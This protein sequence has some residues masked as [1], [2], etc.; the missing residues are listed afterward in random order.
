MWQKGELIWLEITKRR[1]AGLKYGYVYKTQERSDH[2]VKVAVYCV[3]QKKAELWN[4]TPYIIVKAEGNKLKMVHSFKKEIDA[5]IKGIEAQE[6]NKKQIATSF[7]QSDFYKAMT[8]YN[9]ITTS[10]PLNIKA[11]IQYKEGIKLSTV[12]GIR[13]TGVILAGRKKAIPYD[14]VK[15]WI[16]EEKELPLLLTSNI[17]QQAHNNSIVEENF[18]EKEIAVSHCLYN[19]VSHMT[20]KGDPYLYKDSFLNLYWKYLVKEVE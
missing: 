20:R 17:F 9:K 11:M 2:T 4:V 16:I 18:E 15:E 3:R 12:T 19:L 13:S 10:F 7:I 14:F 6:E 1:N 8:L 5:F